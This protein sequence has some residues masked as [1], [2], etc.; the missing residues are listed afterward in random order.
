MSD[1]HHSN[2]TLKATASVKAVISACLHSAQMQHLLDLELSAFYKDCA[3][4][5]V[6]RPFM[7]PACVHVRCEAYLDAFNLS[8]VQA[9]RHA[10]A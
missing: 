6:L 5:V 7:T 1:V 4:H 10:S 2:S 3:S 8:H 9:R